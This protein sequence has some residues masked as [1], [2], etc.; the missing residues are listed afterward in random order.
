M[1]IFTFS[2]IQTALQNA[3]IQQSYNSNKYRSLNV[4]NIGNKNIIIFS[5]ADQMSPF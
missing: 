5:S 4:Q 2:H 1:F 3:L